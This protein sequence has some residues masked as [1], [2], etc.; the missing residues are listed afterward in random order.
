[1]QINTNLPGP[2][3]ARLRREFRINYFFETGT[4]KGD[5]TELAAIMFDKVFTCDVDADAIHA[6]ST[7]LADYPNVQIKYMPS[8][9]FIRLVKR[10]LDQPI[11]YWL[12]AHWCGAA[13]KPPK[14]CPLLEELAEIGGLNGHSV[15]LI[16][17]VNYMTSPPPAPHDPKQWPTIAQ[18]HK[19]I[20][21]WGEDLAYSFVDGPNSQILVYHPTERPK[22][23]API[24]E[25]D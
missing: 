12:D 19:A 24:P 7:R 17:D 3:V 1:M 4:S 16:D 6:A 10:Q 20:E 8:P 23:R 25:E 9:D 18:V 22:L 13:T 2:V 5:A 14:E 11:M 21:A 15:L